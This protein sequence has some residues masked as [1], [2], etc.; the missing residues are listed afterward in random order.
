MTRIEALRA[1]LEKHE[2]DGLTRALVWSFKQADR[3]KLAIKV[4]KLLR[5]AA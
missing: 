3:K 4:P 5:R 1:L 2:P